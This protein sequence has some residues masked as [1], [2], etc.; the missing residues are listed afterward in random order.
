MEVTVTS[1]QKSLCP[2]GMQ[3]MGQGSDPHKVA[4]KLSVQSV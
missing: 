4:L 2:R 1:A 3:F